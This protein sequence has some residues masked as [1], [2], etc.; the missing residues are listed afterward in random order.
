MEQPALVTNGHTELVGSYTIN[1]FKSFNVII[2][3][4]SFPSI[5][6]GVSANAVPH[7]QKLHAR[8]PHVWGNRRLQPGEVQCTGLGLG[9]PPS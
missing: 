6:P 8:V 4:K 3:I 7:Y 2:T 5:L 9:H 1:S